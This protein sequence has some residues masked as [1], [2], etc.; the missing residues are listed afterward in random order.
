[1]YRDAAKLGC[2]ARAQRWFKRNYDK[3]EFFAGS[4]SLWKRGMTRE[5][6]I[7]YL[8]EGISFLSLT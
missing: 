8:N 7:N 1:M 6:A 4:F 5:T 3:Y 2:N